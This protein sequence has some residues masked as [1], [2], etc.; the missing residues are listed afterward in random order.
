MT[1]SIDVRGIPEVQRAL[2]E[3]NVAALKGVSRGVSKATLFVEGEVK[4][5]I[6]GRKAETRSFDTGRFMNSVHSSISDLQGEVSSNVEYAEFLE[7]GTSRISPRRHFRNTK[8]RSADEVKRII[9]VAVREA[10]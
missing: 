6:A 7:Y 3:K 8:E 4:L 9:A 1:F 2:K 5:S 10:L